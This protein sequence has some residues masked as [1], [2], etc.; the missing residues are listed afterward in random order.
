MMKLKE[1][2]NCKGTVRYLYLQIVQKGQ[3]DQM[4]IP[5]DKLSKFYKYV[6]L[7][8]IIAREHL[9]NAVVSAL[10]APKWT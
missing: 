5:R 8:L 7:L 1:I 10:L 9:Y 3:I 4:N 2:I 6:I